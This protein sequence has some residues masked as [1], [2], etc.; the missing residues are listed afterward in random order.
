[1]ADIPDTCPHCGTVLSKW[2]VP[3]GATWNDEYF[4]VCFNNE[5]SYYQRGWEWMMEQYS[6][7]A[8]YRFAINPANGATLMIP[9]WSDDATR[10]MIVTE[11]VEDDDGKGEMT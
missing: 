4:M 11:D 2:L 5:C 8:S 1:M 6:Q 9:V 7:K 10:E 3:E